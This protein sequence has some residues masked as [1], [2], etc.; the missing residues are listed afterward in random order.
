MGPELIIVILTMPNK[1]IRKR[2]FNRHPK[3]KK[4]VDILM[5]KLFSLNFFIFTKI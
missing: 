4:L 3:D 1:N 2:L 5:V